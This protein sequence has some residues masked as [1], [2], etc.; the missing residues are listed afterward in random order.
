MSNRNVPPAKSGIYGKPNFLGIVIGSSIAIIV[1]L[2][3]A[4]FVLGWDARKLIPHGPKAEPNAMVQLISG[5]V[6]G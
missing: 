6:E 1:I 3:A 5:P 2:L 4:Y